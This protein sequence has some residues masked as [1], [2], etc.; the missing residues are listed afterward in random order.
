MPLLV[1]IGGGAGKGTGGQ[2]IHDK[3]DPSR[4]TDGDHLQEGDYQGCEK[5]GKGAVK[6]SANGDDH[7]LGLIFQ[8]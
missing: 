3:A 8:E 2:D 4:I 7:I 5:C 1:H 6:E